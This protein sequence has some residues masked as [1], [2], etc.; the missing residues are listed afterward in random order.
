MSIDTSK[1]IGPIVGAAGAAISIGIL[2][3]TVKNISDTMKPKKKKLN[4]DNYW[5][6]K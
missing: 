4:V 2:T 5:V 6:R 1:F 3:K